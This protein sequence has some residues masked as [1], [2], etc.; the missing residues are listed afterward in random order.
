MNSDKHPE[1]GE[2]IVIF[3]RLF[4]GV[5]T[6]IALGGCMSTVPIKVEDNSVFIPALRAGINLDGDKYHD[7]SEPQTGRAVEFGFAKARGSGNQS[8]A[9][10]TQQVIINYRAFTGPQQLRNDFD[11]NFANISWRWR[12][13]FGERSL[14]LELLGGFG[15]TSLGLT[16]S[17]PTQRASGRFDNAGGQGGIGLIWRLHPRTSLQA[18][19]TGLIST[20]DWGVNNMGRYELFL[21]QALG[22]NLTL[23]TGY[24]KWALNGHCGTNMSDFQ[25]RFSGLAVVLDWDFNYKNRAKGEDVKE[26]E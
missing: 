22:K 24:A 13:F 19:V 15:F 5:L 21:A 6:T 14:G 23:R 25:L 8:I 16:V 26:P 20:D 9:S 12:K 4:A 2:C 10:N 1:S 17:S 11:F 7:A 18:R 3:V